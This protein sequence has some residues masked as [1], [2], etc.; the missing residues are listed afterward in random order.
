MKT[1]GLE[2][3]S[4]SL[5]ETG[6]RMHITITPRRPG[7]HG[8]H[9]GRFAVRDSGQTHLSDNLLRLTRALPLQ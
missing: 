4:Q 9:N 5:K 2:T 6:T 3:V 7:V 1:V 8:R